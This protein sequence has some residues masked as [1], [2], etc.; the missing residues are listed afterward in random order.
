MLPELSI[1][2]YER[3]IHIDMDNIKEGSHG[4]FEQRM[5][6]EITGVSAKAGYVD[7]SKYFSVSKTGQTWVMEEWEMRP[8]RL[9]EGDQI[10]GE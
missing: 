7:E 2:R 5:H 8:D 6:I 1:K 4:V 9:A 3:L 10:T